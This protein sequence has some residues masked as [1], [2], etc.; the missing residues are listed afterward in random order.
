MN[1]SDF[2]LHTATYGYSAATRT[3]WQPYDLY[4]CCYLFTIFYHADA[5]DAF[6]AVDAVDAVANSYVARMSRK[7]ARANVVVAVQVVALAAMKTAGKR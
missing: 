3:F 2:P 4:S 7:V 6:D 5:V 1:F